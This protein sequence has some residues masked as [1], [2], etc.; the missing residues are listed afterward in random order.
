[1]KHTPIVALACVVLLTGCRQEPAKLK[2][3]VQAQLPS[4]HLYINGQVW[5]LVP[6]DRFDDETEYGE[7]D[8]DNQEI[9][10]LASSDPSELREALWHEIF[11]AGAC[12]H[13][14]DQW[15]N[16]I[17]PTDDDHP[18]IYHLADFMHNFTRD[19]K[20]FVTWAAE[21]E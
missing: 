14:G 4:H 2:A 21:G 5:D 20:E 8:C 19:N 12:V 15:W 6:V 1:M 10:Y 13:G 9:D 18:G 17:H 16:S 11:H 3:H 7:T